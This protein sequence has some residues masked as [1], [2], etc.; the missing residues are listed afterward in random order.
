MAMLTINELLKWH[1]SN[2]NRFCY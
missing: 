2:R 1:K